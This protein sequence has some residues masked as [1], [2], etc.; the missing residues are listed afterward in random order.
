MSKTTSP[1]DIQT[2]WISKYALS[3]GI[4]EA[5]AEVR[6]GKAY[7]GAPFATFTYFLMGR[8]AHT[9]REEAVNA[10]NAEREKK[11]ASLKKQLAKL[12]VLTF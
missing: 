7:P 1:E 3:A 6:D 11:I 9:S 10:A 12:Q 8:D 5:K 4:S 2:V